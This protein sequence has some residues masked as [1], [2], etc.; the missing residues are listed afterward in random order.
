MNDMWL[1]ITQQGGLSCIRQVV[2]HGEVQVTLPN[3]IIW[4]MIDIS[5][6]V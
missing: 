3:L 1:K 6:H 2:M 5:D 4:A